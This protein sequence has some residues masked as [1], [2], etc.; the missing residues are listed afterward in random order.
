MKLTTLCIVLSGLFLINFL[1]PAHGAQQR[2]YDVS[3]VSYND[4]TK[5]IVLKY[6]RFTGETWILA[7]KGYDTIPEDKAIPESLYKIDIIAIKKGWYATRIDTNTGRTWTVNQGKW[8]E[9]R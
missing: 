4:D 5:M 7:G 2:Q 3:S 6:N 1:V 9:V 8:K